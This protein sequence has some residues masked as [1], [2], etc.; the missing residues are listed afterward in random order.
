[1]NLAAVETVYPDTSY[2]LAMKCANDS[3][4]AAWLAFHPKIEHAS[5][6]WS[7]W[8]HLELFTALRQLVAA[9]PQ[10]ISEA[11]CRRVLALTQREVQRGYFGYADSDWREQLREARELSAQFAWHQ[12]CRA[13]DVLH[14]AIAGL[15]GVDL[16]VTCDADQAK[17]ATAAGLQTRLVAA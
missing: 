11:E 1:M 4:H 6:L 17:L 5:L 14:V 12:P 2:W 8:T 7:A 13:G 9:T 16:F 10:R 3:H 15:A